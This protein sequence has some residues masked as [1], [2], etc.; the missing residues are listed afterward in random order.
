LPVFIVTN[1]ALIVFMRRQYP[2]EF[3]PILHGL[4]PIVSILIFIAAIWLSIDPWPA[5]PLNTFP[6]IVVAVIV[7]AVIWSMILKSQNSPVLKRLGDVLF[8][9]GGQKT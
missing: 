1:L 5:A 9:D 6:F 2:S 8:L 3:S 4:F 7:L